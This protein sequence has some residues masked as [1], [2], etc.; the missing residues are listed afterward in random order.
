MHWL[1][2][3]LSI[4]LLVVAMQPSMPGWAVFLML[5]GSLVAVVAWILGWLSLRISSGSRHEMHIISPDE[6]RQM[7]EQAEARKAA[8]AQPPADPP[9]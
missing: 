5:I 4:F 3:V 7:R 2:L 1:Y 9:A 6:L 8:A